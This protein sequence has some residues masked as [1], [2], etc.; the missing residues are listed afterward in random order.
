[1]RITIDNTGQTVTLSPPYAPDKPDDSLQRITDVY[2]AKKLVTQNGVH[3][4][5]TRIDSLHAQQDAS[6]Q[7]IAFDTILGKTV[8]LII[9][10]SNMATLSVDA[11]IRPANSTMT[12]STDTLRIMKFNGTTQLYEATNLITAE[13][14]NLDALNNRDGS[15][16]HYTNAAADFANKCIIK[17][18]LK[19]ETQVLFNT[20][21]RN[22]A[23]ATV[24][25]EV[26]VERTDNLPCA[27][28]PSSTT[29]VNGAEVFLNT[30]TIGRFRLVNRN[31]YEI[32]SRV[33]GTP[34]ASGLNANNFTDNPYNFFGML[35]TSR[36]RIKQI[37]NASST[38]VVYF[39]YDKYDNEMLVTTCAKTNV[40]G[41]E[42][43]VQLGAVPP[44][45]ISETAAP[46]GGNAQ[47]NF[48][49]ANGSIVTTGN[50]RNGPRERLFPG[51][52]RIVQYD[53][54]GT[55]VD[56]VRMPNS[57]NI[58]RNG[59][60]IAFGFSGSQRRFCNPECFA[61]FVGILAEVGIA[62]ITS[63]GMC[64][65]DATSYP[66]V[67]HPN[68]DSVDTSYLVNQNTN[69][70]NLLDAFIGWN[71]TEVIAGTTQQRWLNNAHR[72]RADHDTHLHSGNF[73]SNS[74]EPFY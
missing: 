50:H 70:Q 24:N 51:R 33:L 26:V 60:R 47:S 46:A 6:G 10:T 72:Y 29:E 17:L 31:F 65:G 16:A 27:F 53:A 62:G 41:R 63:T 69:Q 2:F 42:N 38:D 45:Y 44:R 40:M 11:V 43:G 67:T 49:Y 68:G 5:F 55:N 66:S 15:H 22:M 13:V 9:E 36:K 20:W 1:M 12:G 71:F 30:D 74:I 8:Y 58:N 28:G 32:Y 56:L 34:A 59:V 73:D 54:S 21:A 25:L 52:L 23:A 57:L 14:G 19:P 64:F 37:V 61:A 4:A 3:V 7:A 39:Y 35:G 48:T 18:Q